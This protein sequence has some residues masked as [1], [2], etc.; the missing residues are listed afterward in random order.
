MSDL[1]QTLKYIRS[2]GR[3]KRERTLR[4]KQLAEAVRNLGNYRWTG[5]YDI[6]KEMVTII[7]YSG[8]GAP[9]YL[10]FPVTQGLTGSAI[11]GKSTVVVGDVRT[12]PR[13][14]T[15]FGTTRSEIIVPILHPQSG[16]V[17]GTIDVESERA[18]AFSAE[19]QK[20][21]EQCARMALPLWIEG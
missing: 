3:A 20:A 4:A 21:L 14:L 9:A 10:T 13:Y 18:N 6:G 12:D 8:P 2:L 17:I 16:V 11:R 1:K 15:A 5:V 19:D 7:A